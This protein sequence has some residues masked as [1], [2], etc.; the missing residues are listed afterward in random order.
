MTQKQDSLADVR[1]NVRTKL[2]LLWATLMSLYIYADY[3]QLMTPHKLENMLNQ[4]T[5]VGNTT[6]TILLIFSI[7]LIIPSLM[8]PGSFLLSASVSRWLNII[9]AI[10]YACI[11]VLIIIARIH[12]EWGGFFVLYQFVELGVFFLIIRFAWRWP[13]EYAK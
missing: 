4:K 6:P 10:I 1:L 8:I 3:F 12:Q 7:V 11:S 9:V 13:K 5:P 2:A